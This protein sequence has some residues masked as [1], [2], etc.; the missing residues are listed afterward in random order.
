[1]Q[2]RN[3]SDSLLEGCGNGE[4]NKDEQNSVY[5]ANDINWNLCQII[6]YSCF[7]LYFYLLQEN[8]IS[9]EPGGNLGGKK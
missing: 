1:M 7:S 8:A 3:R 6:S 2:S 5:N 9:Q 4:I